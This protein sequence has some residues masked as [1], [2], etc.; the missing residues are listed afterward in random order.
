MNHPNKVYGWALGILARAFETTETSIHD[1]DQLTML[2]LSIQNNLK[3]TGMREGVKIA[4]NPDL[5]SLRFECYGPSAAHAVALDVCGYQRGKS[6]AVATP[7]DIYE[8]SRARP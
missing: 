2:K 4:F 1:D 6:V 5:Q 8:E 7:K 3:A